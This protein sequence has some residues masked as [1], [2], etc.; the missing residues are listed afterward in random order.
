MRFNGFLQ[1]V[2]KSL[3]LKKNN[4][5]SNVINKTFGEDFGEEFWEKKKK[6]HHQLI[7]N[8]LH[9]FP[10]AQIFTIAAQACAWAPSSLWGPN[11]ANTTA[12]G[13]LTQLTQLTQQPVGLVPLTQLTLTSCTS[14]IASNRETSP[15]LRYLSPSK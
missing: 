8:R 15:N 7:P 5:I 14:F 1:T 9:S 12:F 2:S 11:T 6:N 3:S 10:Q 4:G 13:A